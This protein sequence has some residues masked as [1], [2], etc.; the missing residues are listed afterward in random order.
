MPFQSRALLAAVAFF[1]RIPCPTGVGAVGGVG[2]P[3]G[4]GRTGDQQRRRSQDQGEAPVDP[5]RGAVDVAGPDAARVT[6]AD[7]QR[8]GD[9]RGG[10]VLD[11]DHQEVPE[12]PRARA[13]AVDALDGVTARDAHPRLDHRGVIDEPLPYGDLAAGDVPSV[14]GADPPVERPPRAVDLHLAARPDQR[15]RHAPERADDRGGAAGGQAHRALLNRR[16]SPG[17]PAPA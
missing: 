4:L 9:R 3:G 15:V 5:D 10:G 8:Q 7:G 13:R 1:T 17:A 16:H 12:R 2:G 6:R 11:L 14:V